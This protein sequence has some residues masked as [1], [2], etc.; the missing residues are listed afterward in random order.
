MS[1]QLVYDEAYM[2]VA[3]IFADLSHG[4]EIRVGSC[5]VHEGQILSQ[6]W[7]GMPAGMG[8]DTRNGEGLTNPEVIHAEANALMKLAKNGGRAFGATVYTTH[9]P[10]YNCAGLL[11]QAGVKRVVYRDEYDKKAVKFLKERGV[12]V[13]CIKPSS[14]TLK[15]KSKESKS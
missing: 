2:G 11:L 1:K 12:K 3:E 4:T 15:R 10:C 9:S 7:N 5:V 13:D 14:R 8:N 6:G